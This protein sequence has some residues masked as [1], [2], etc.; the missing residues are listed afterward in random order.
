LVNMLPHDGVGGETP[1]AQEPQ[2]GLDQNQRAHRAFPKLAVAARAGL[3]D[4]LA[5]ITPEQFPRT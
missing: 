5:S 1:Q 3:R 4:A 2:R